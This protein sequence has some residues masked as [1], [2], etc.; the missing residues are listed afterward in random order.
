VRTAKPV[1]VVEICPEMLDPTPVT[2][3]ENIVV[4]DKSIYV[5]QK[6]IG[7]EN[8]MMWHEILRLAGSIEQRLPH[9]LGRSVRV[10]EWNHEISDKG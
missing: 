8:L 4:G 1:K 10:E 2:F 6:H 5:T 7:A 9:R 3:V